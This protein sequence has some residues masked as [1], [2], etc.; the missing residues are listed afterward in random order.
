[1]ITN[2]IRPQL[3]IRQL[4]EVLPS[5][6]EPTLNAFIY[7]PQYKLNRYNEKEERATMFGTNYAATNDEAGDDK[8]VVSYEGVDDGDLVDLSNVELYGE[9]MELSLASFDA[10]T[11][12]SD[13]FFFNSAR[14]PNEIICRSDAGLS[15]PEVNIGDPEGAD[16]SDGLDGR[17]ISIGDLIVVTENIVSG[18]GD[19]VHRRRVTDIKR[20]TEVS[21]YDD[22]A[23]GGKNIASSIDVTD[24]KGEFISAVVSSDQ[25][26]ITA[27]AATSDAFIQAGAAFGGNLAEK[28]NVR[29][30]QGASSDE[31][32]KARIRTVSNHFESD[33]VVVTWDAGVAS[34]DIPNV[35][36]SVS[37]DLG[38]VSGKIN[39]GDSFDFTVQRAYVALSCDSA[40]G[41]V[42]IVG[43]YLHKSNTTI[44]AECVTGD[45][46]GVNS[47]WNISDSSG[48]DDVATVSGSALSA[49]HT[50]GGSGI[51]ISLDKVQQAAGDEFTIE[52]TAAG[53]TG[54]FSVLVLDAPAGDLSLVDD[55]DLPN[56]GITNVEVRKVYSGAISRRGANAPVEQWNAKSSG[57]LLEHG[58][59][60]L[61]YGFSE[62]DNSTA[63]LCKFASANA[64]SPKL[65]ASYKELVPAM[66]NEAISRINKASDLIQFGKK[67][68]DNPIGFGA[69]SAFSGS[70]GKAIYLARVETD[71]LKGYQEVLRKAENI[72]ALYAH[73]PMSRDFDVQLEVR[74]HVDSMSTEYNKKWRRAYISTDTP[75]DY[76]VIG[77]D[78]SATISPSE[79]G[80]VV[81]SD[82]D[83]RF[84]A[85]N[86]KHG[87]LFRIQFTSSVW[88]DSVYANYEDGGYIVH[89]VIDEETLILKSGPTKSFS[90]PRR[91]EVWKKDNAEN[92]ADFIAARSSSLGSRRINNVFAD[93]A[94]YLTDDSE[95][96]SLDPMYLAAE[97]AGL[98]TAV[99]PQQGLTN[100]EIAL[101]AA[102]PAMYTKYTQGQLDQ[103]AANGSFIITQEFEDGPR[104]IRHQL[105]TKTDS[106][107]LYYEDSCGVNIDEI[108]F[109]V[110]AELRPYI[111]R[112]NVNPETVQDI[113]YDMFEILSSKTTA[114]GFGNSIGPALIGFTD[115]VVRINDTFKDRID[116]SAKLEV[117]LPLNVIDV[118]LNATASFNEGEITLESLGISR[119]GQ[120]TANLAEELKSTLTTEG[121][122]IQYVGSES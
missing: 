83:G 111:G 110:K 107:N 28:F 59:A 2:Y 118:T 45:S 46:T 86:V 20:S 92:I 55:E 90:T 16:L 64:G 89:R 71:D 76:R 96:I 34:F 50:Y 11:E 93:G 6:S 91:Y 51:T 121:L 49:G 36:V 73:A 66:P 10:E 106:G 3:L 79:D 70:Q 60:G 100:T 17:P 8:L 105:T 13:T 119:V 67:D 27:S 98:R 32:G 80:N 68:V 18:A 54:V 58:L 4:L 122:P 99:L 29:F 31:D 84:V 43:N 82:P 87:D 97:I 40:S 95:F 69:A 115:L 26:S 47:V 61:C 109:Q 37:I 74:A 104:F 94:Q 72:D 48:L 19:K 88:G 85:S 24:L 15:S 33:N 39:A 75:S 22:A 120:T 117:P 53:E 113:F 52:C 81:V 21:F 65:F 25:V 44:I 5:V 62:Q 35:G 23:C 56:L 116:V 77:G 41:D 7:G 108:S 78:S 30:T 101:V 12:D 14:R 9:D 42:S 103:I 114:P 112:R 1:M 57:V 38:G 102:A 63:R